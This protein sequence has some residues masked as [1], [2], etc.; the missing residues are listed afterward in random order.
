MRAVGMV[1]KCLGLLLIAMVQV[2]G[3]LGLAFVT[4]LAVLSHFV[5]EH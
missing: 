4:L 2:V 5:P 1:A 3:V